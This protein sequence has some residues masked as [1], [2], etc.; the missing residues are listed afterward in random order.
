MMRRTVDSIDDHIAPVGQLLGQ[1]LGGDAANDWSCRPR[2]AD[3]I[4]LPAH[5]GERPLHRADNVAAL[6]PGLQG[7]FSLRIE[8]P[9]ICAGLLCQTHPFKTPQSAD[10]QAAVELGGCG[11][12]SRVE[13]DY[14]VDRPLLNRPIDPGP[15]LLADFPIQALP[16]LALRPQSQPS[17]GEFGRPVAHSVGDVL[18][19]ND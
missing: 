15:A 13:I 14:A 19:G 17:G 10:L 7:R 11:I 6:A 9:C 12:D 2:E 5:L 1:P 3:E 18:P 16:Y 4:K 8:S